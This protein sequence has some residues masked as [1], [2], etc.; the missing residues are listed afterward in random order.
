MADKAGKAQP[1]EAGKGAVVKCWGEKNGSKIR[2]LIRP[3]R[4][5]PPAPAPR[6]AQ[7]LRGAVYGLSVL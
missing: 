1:R 4:P 6:T 2:V 3:P 5:P 7:R